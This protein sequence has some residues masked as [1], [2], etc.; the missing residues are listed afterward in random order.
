MNKASF[1]AKYNDVV[2]GLF[3]TGQSRGIGSDDVREQ[4]ADIVA[5]VPFTP[6]DTYS[7]ASP[8]IDITGTT[9]LTGTANPSISSYSNGQTFKLIP[10]SS[11]TGVSTLNLNGV[12]AKKLLVSP[13]I[14]A[15]TGDVIAGQ[16]Y[17]AVYHSSYDPPNGAFLLL[18]VPVSKFRGAFDA[19]VT[20]VYPST[21][22]S[23]VSGAVM[24]GDEWFVSV[25]GDNT[26]YGGT[27]PVKTILKALINTPGQ[28][29]GNWKIS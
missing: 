14:Q 27:M 12:G 18:G 11:I 19:S 7:W 9:T 4:V 8:F 23:G 15:S 28:T 29:A 13:T 26:D 20:D 3:K 1:L 21:G 17:F 24:A 5:S 25:S 22:G 10:G 16:V 2:S 6:D